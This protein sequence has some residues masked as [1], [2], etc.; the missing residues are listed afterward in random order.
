MSSVVQILHFRSF[1]VIS[2]MEYRNCA[3]SKLKCLNIQK[4][5]TNDVQAVVCYVLFDCK[6]AGFS[7]REA[8]QASVLYSI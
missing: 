7:S 4:A 2:S 8:Q 3:C 1:H 6:K 5:N